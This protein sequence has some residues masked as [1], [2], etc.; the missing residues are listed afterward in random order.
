[1]DPRPQVQGDPSIAS[2]KDICL[3]FS[4]WK[5]FGCRGNDISGNFLL[6]A[7]LLPGLLFRRLIFFFFFKPPGRGRVC[8]RGWGSSVPRGM[9]KLS[10][11]EYFPLGHLGLRFTGSLGGLLTTSGHREVAI[12]GTWGTGMV[13]CPKYKPDSVLE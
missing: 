8:G 6:V 1:M 10:S 5:A 7:W 13:P 11:S 4:G 9:S 12:G 2:W 3:P